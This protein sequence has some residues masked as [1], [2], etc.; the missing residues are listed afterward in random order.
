MLK[1]E[2][3]DENTLWRIPGLDLVFVPN[4]VAVGAVVFEKNANRQ[5]Q[6]D[7]QTDDNF[8]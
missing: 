3:V 4:V 2:V 5:R 1:A 8:N 6:T 7:R